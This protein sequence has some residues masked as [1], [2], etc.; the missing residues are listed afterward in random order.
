MRAP[1]FFAIPGLSFGRRLFRDAVSPRKPRRRVLRVLF[2]LIGVALL[3]VLL[4]FGLLIGAGML[5]FAV[6]SR[7]LHRRRAAADV[8]RDR[9]LDGQ[10]RVL[11]KPALGAGR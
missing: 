10:Y 9:T 8:R 5:A 3:A 2:T 11:R 4:V 1:R 6:V 7:L